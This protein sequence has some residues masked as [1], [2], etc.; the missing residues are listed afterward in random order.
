M[1]LTVFAH[2]EACFHHGLQ[3]DRMR[4]AVGKGFVSAAFSFSA[5]CRNWSS[6]E[7][8]WTGLITFV[9]ARLQSVAA[10]RVWVE[11]GRQIAAL[12][13]LFGAEKAAEGDKPNP[14]RKDMS[15]FLDHA[16]LHASTLS[17]H[18]PRGL[19]AQHGQ[20]GAG[21]I[22]RSNCSSDEEA[23]GEKWP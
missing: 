4:P 2:T 13:I 9:E 22:R 7:A 23:V 1:P 11:D 10:P 20:P 3:L 5:I 6:R 21:A 19:A 14:F 12:N 16:I 8:L 17:H 15:R 18:C